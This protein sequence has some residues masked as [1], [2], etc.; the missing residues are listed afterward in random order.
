MKLS[1]SQSLLKDWDDYSKGLGCG[2]WFKARHIDKI[3]T[4]P[5]PAMLKGLR[6]EYLCTGALLRDG[7]IP[8]ELLTKTGN[9]S[10]TD[11]QKVEKQAERFKEAIEFYGVEILETSKIIEWECDDYKRKG[12]LDILAKI[13]KM[14]EFKENPNVYMKPFEA[15]IDIKS[16][17]LLDNKF[18]QFGWA[19]ENLP[20]RN[21]LTEQPV[22]YKSIYRENGIKDIPFYWFVHS[23]T[24][25]IDSRIIE[26]RVGDARIDE[27]IFKVKSAVKAIES[28]LFLEFKAHPTVKRCFNCPLFKNCKEKITVPKVNIVEIY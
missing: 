23:N 13:H 17:G 11:N 12:V 28:E 16:T 6:F 8:P 1:I 26:A 20:F 9:I 27:Q 25:D 10:K 21:K 7:S 18:E 5:T 3:K 15:I 19:L 4:K 22:D 2:L 14:P 24:N